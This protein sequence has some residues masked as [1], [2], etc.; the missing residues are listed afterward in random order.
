MPS[1][2]GPSHSLYYSALHR[3][4]LW[5]GHL[6]RAFGD[7]AKSDWPPALAKLDGSHAR[8]FARLS[9]DAELGIQEPLSLVKVMD[10]T[11]VDS[12]LTRLAEELDAY[13]HELLT[14]MASHARIPDWVETLE[15]TSMLWG[16]EL[17]QECLIAM[18]KARAHRFS[19]P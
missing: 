16:R 2:V 4:R 15:Q 1:L 13:Q 17:A 10:D 9:H 18:N 11:P 8:L 12:F 14:L 7:V 5:L 19:L 6:A 3:R